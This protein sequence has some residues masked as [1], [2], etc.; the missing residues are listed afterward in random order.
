MDNKETKHYADALAAGTTLQGGA[1]RYRIERALGQGSFGITYL[2]ATR[3]KVSGALGELEAD[4]RVAVKE[5]FMKDVNGR[6]ESTVTSGSKDGLFADYKRK[7]R[8]E[9]ENLSRLRHPHI[10]RVLETFEANGTAYYAMEYCEGGCLNELADKRGG[11][12]EEEAVGY[13]VQIGE[14]LAYMH[15]HKMLHLDVKPGNAMLRGD[16]SVALIDFGLSKQYGEDGEPESS[17]SVGGG[18][19]GYAPLEQAQYR[20][21]RDFPVTMDVYALG[22]TLF[23]LLTGERPPEASAVLNDGFPAGA[24]R[25]RKVSEATIAIAEK[26]MSPL[27]KDRYPSVNAMLAALKGGAAPDDEETEV[28]EKNKKPDEKPQ[29]TKKQEEKKPPVVKPEKKKKSGASKWMVAIGAGVAVLV[30]NL[31]RVNNNDRERVPAEV[32]A[33][34]DLPDLSDVAATVAAADSAAV[35]DFSDAADSAAVAPEPDEQRQSQAEQAAQRERERQERERQAEEARLARER[36][37]QRQRENDRVYQYNQGVECYNDKDYEGAATWWRKAAGQGHAEAQYWLGR[38]YHHGR[39]VEQN[40]AAAARWYSRAAVQG[41]VYAQTNLGMC[42]YNGR[43]VAQDYAEAVKWFRKAA[44]QGRAS[45]QYNLG[46]CYY[47]GRGVEQ[48]YAEAAK[49]FRKAAEQG[50]ADAENFL[51]E[52]YYY[53]RGVAQDY[54]EAAKWYRKAA[55]QGSAGAQFNLGWCYAKGQGVAR[56]EDEAVRWWRKAAEQ[57][58]ANAKNALEQ[59]GL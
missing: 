35:A 4:M 53:G 56:D 26:A 55:E 31:A 28:D 10:V 6:E 32:A 54:A 33:L 14:A 41:N 18:T 48:D 22:A 9:A 42:Y 59:R 36:E 23:K 15:A 40:P 43:G 45:A 47:N 30:S 37:E 21:G 51:G 57:G 7:F 46:T 5:F 34:A 20:E 50:D 11:L 24:L 38:C 27:R 39:G 58:N 12:P 17:T 44:E 25:R 16:G 8:R 19:P 2:A 3:V 52:A 29:D 1:Y 13:A 49:W